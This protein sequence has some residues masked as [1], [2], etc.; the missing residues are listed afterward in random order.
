MSNKP[1]KITSPDDLQN[2]Y[3]LKSDLMMFCK[4][5]GLAT[6][7]AKSDLIERIGVYLSTGQRMGYIP[8]SKQGERDS[9]KCI[10]KNTPVRNYNMTQKQEDFLSNTWVIN[11]NLTLTFANSPI[12]IILNQI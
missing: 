10:T 11:L 7:G 2:Y 5:H 8:L 3:W 9:L 4:K 6:Q 12:T 1:S